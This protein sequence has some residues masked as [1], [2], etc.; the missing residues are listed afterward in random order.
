MVVNFVNFNLA[1]VFE[2]RASEVK[3]RLENSQ[4]YS[5]RQQLVNAGNLF[6]CLYNKRNNRHRYG[7]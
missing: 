5:S 3:N 1:I 7:W 2:S 4:A 6:Y